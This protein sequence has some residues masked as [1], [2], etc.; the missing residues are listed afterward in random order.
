MWSSNPS[1]VE[2]LGREIN[3]LRHMVDSSRKALGE[4][5]QKDSGNGEGKN[6]L[7]DYLSLCSPSCEDE[8]GGRSHEVACS[9]RL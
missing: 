6:A 9:R 4:K 8:G 1:V 3:N 5:K 7:K 2:I